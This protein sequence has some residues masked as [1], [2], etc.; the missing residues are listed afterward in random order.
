MW[1]IFSSDET[2]WT[3]VSQKAQLRRCCVLSDDSPDSPDLLSS[4]RQSGPPPVSAARLTDESLSWV[5]PGLATQRSNW[6][7]SLSLSLSPSLSPL[8]SS[9]SYLTTDCTGKLQL[10]R[11]LDTNNL[12]CDTLPASDNCL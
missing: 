12:L 9:L 11:A 2:A 10:H 7:V 6:L 5:R 1:I 8:L 3:S 4:A